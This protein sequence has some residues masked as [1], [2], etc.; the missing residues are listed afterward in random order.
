LGVSAGKK[1]G[2]ENLNPT[3][4]LILF[5]R[6]GLERG[7]SL[8]QLLQEFTHDRTGLE[9]KDQRSF[10][11]GVLIWWTELEQRRSVPTMPHQLQLP[12]RQN[13]LHLLTRGLRGESILPALNGLEQ[14]VFEQCLEEMDHQ[15]ALLPLQALLPLLLLQ[16]PA[17]LLLLLGPL[18]SQVLS[19][20]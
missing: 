14:D 8:R 15:M 19:S 9:S 13:L 12:A 20:L 2:M 16:F 3:L 17:L 11:L 1:R 10:R 18:L 5:L 6:L 4:Q 7:D